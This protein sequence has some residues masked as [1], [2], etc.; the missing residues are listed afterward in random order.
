[1]YL[2][3]AL[4]Y[5]RAYNSLNNRRHPMN[6]SRLAIEIRSDRLGR[7]CAY[8]YSRGAMRW[9]RMPLVDAEIE[10]AGRA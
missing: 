4:A 9:I 5:V 1:M 7:A 10:L 2:V 3:V 8:Y 6:L